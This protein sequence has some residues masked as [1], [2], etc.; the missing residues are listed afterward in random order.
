MLF[1]VDS[2][3]VLWEQRAAPRAADREPDEDD[4]RAADRRAPPPGERVLITREA[5]AYEGSGIGVLPRGKKVRL[6]AMLNGLLLVSG[7]DA[8]VALAQHD[9]GSVGASSSG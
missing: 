3:E 6:E 2:G 8:A 9:A 4:D 7:N 1:D 5:L